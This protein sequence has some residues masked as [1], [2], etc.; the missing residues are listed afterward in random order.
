MRGLLAGL[1]ALGLAVAPG[2]AVAQRVKGLRPG[3]GAKAVAPGKAVTPGKAAALKAAMA[4]AFGRSFEP[5][6][7][8]L[9][10]VNAYWLA[11]LSAMIYPQNLAP[12][13]R[14]V[15]EDTLQRSPQRFEAAFKQVAEPHFGPQASYRFF[16]RTSGELYNPEAMVITTPAVVLVVF[17]GTD[18]LVTAS[19]GILG[20]LVAELGEW[21]VTDANVLPLRAVGDGLA[22]KAHRGM[23]ESLDVVRGALRDHV[24]AQGKPVWVAGHSLGAAHAQLMAGTLAAARAKVHGLYLYNGPHPGDRDFAAALDARLG[25]A[26]IQRFEYLDDPIALLPPQTTVSVLLGGGRLPFAS[27]LGGFGRVGLRNV[28]RKL[29]GGGALL[30]GAPERQE[31]ELD[32]RNLGR[33]GLFSPLAICYHNPHW[34]TAGLY[35]QIPKAARGPL[36]QPLSLEGL[37][38]CTPAAAE[39]GRTGK[40]FE[41]Q[42]VEDAAEAAGEAVAAVRY[43][44]DALLA[45]LDGHAIAPG[46]YRLRCV[47][48]GRYLEVKPD[49]VREN[50]CGVQLGGEGRGN[51]RQR[52]Q[53]LREGPSYRIKAAVNGRSLD[54]DRGSSKLQLWDGNPVG[55]VNANQKWLFYPVG[56]PADRRYVLLNGATVVGADRRVVDAIN[57]DTNKAGGRVTTGRPKGSDPTQVWV[58]EPTR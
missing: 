46:T 8:D 23:K 10:L 12:L 15:S 56:A 27:P 16:S 18:K 3:L 19:D 40:P 22:G 7:A 53:V 14:G 58:L 45:N 32:R 36:P 6:A 38:G 42:L 54:M 34:I 4:G 31:G 39:T 17:R 24:L 33:S 30:R 28:F 11:W 49:C 35:G 1:V 5:D 20:A 44:V 13:V 29:E 2:G 51:T 26:R 55:G 50:G 25:K 57:A 21:I 9:N 52:F 48:G 47:Q 37:P 41:Q 43:E